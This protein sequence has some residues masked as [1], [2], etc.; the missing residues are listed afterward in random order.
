MLQRSSRSCFEHLRSRPYERF[1]VSNQ[2]LLLVLTERLIR[3]SV[4]S[5]QHWNH[6]TLMPFAISTQQVSFSPILA[7]LGRPNFLN[8]QN[9]P[10][11]PGSLIRFQ[12]RLISFGVSCKRCGKSGLDCCFFRCCASCSVHGSRG[13]KESSVVTYSAFPSPSDS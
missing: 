10:S 12:R 1:P 3:N 2:N 9:F 11:R 8:P 4:K 6:N 7:T 5:L 13:V